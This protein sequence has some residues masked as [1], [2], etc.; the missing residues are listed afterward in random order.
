MPEVPSHLDLFC[1][2]GGFAL[3]FEWAGFKP[4][5]GLDIHPPSV[6]TYER[7][8]PDAATILSDIRK[9]SNSDLERKLRAAPLVITAGVPCEGFS[10]SNR[11]RNRF[12]DERV[13]LF[14]EFLRVVEY[15]E[16]PYIVLENVSAL[17]RHSNGFFKNEIEGGMRAL[18]YQVEAKVLNAVDYGVPQ[19][20]RRVFFV[21]WKPEWSFFWPEA[22][23]GSSKGQAPLVTVWD[24]I[25]DLPPLD[26]DQ[27]VERYSAP[28]T[29]TYS[30]LMR[31]DCR[32]L[33]NHRA[34]KHPPDTIAMI[35][36]TVP[37]EPMYPKFKQRIRLRADMP[38]PTLVSGGIRPQF[39]Y[40]HPT[41]PRGLSVRE[42]A[43]IQSFPDRYFFEGGVVQGR[44]QT[45]DAVPP[46]MSKA[47]A[48]KI[49]EGLDRGPSGRSAEPE[50]AV[51]TELF[52][53]IPPAVVG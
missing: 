35:G 22:Q 25:G 33:T 21:G 36:T 2:P 52:V 23:H 13:F 43:R 24:A 17:T 26:S 51:Q 18:G 32:F 6:A 30:A 49:R 14:V 19:R 11:N 50:T 7:N 47:I 28:P 5:L 16:P 20:R 38:C 42:R 39:H 44:V 15:F 37:G 1:G 8:H 3:G 41:Q 4:I 10:M 53:S 45:G 34:P 27:E 29:S 9:V 40:G 31:G 48:Q 12:V 46:L